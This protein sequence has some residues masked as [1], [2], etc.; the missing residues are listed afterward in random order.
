[1]AAIPDKYLD[2]LQQKK[3]FAN[4]ATLMPDGSPQVTPVWVDYAGGA[5]R[6]RPAFPSAIE[7]RT[8][9]RSMWRYD[10]PSLISGDE[11]R[12]CEGLK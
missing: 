9:P 2:L 6:V 12:L 3:A 8:A 1:M 4:L 11:S 10:P 5:V 7:R